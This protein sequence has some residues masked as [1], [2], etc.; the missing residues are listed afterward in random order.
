MNVESMSHL[1][2]MQ[3]NL[4]KNATN[5]KFQYQICR[6]TFMSMDCGK[7]VNDPNQWDI[8]LLACLCISSADGRSKV[9][10]EYI[11]SFFYI[12]LL[13]TNSTEAQSVWSKIVPPSHAKLLFESELTKDFKSPWWDRWCNINLQTDF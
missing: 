10:V 3:M 12:F 1:G 13:G 9:E 4:V 8:V 6:V 7:S 11:R 5:W 2:V